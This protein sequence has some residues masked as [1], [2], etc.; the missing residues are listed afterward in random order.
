MNTSIKNCIVIFIAA[1]ITGLAIFLLSLFNVLAVEAAASVLPAANLAALV[2][3]AVFFYALVQT[4]KNR[5]VREA[6]CCCGKLAIIG[7]IGTLVFSLLALLLLNGT[8][9]ILFDLALGFVFFFLVMLLAGA[10]C[11][12]TILYQCRRNEC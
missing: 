5:L 2:L 12:L 7:F 1:V 6:V 10:G 11:I 4:E 9:K 8:I 3:Y